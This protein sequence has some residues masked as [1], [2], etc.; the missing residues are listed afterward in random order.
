MNGIHANTVLC[1]NNEIV[2][3]SLDNEA[4]MMCIEK[5]SYYGLDAIGNDVWQYLAEPRSFESVCDYLL[6]RYSVDKA[7]C[8]H[9]VEKFLRM[10]IGQEL[11]EAS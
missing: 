8:E 11:I 9:D 5:G 4:V 1:R 2:S 10:M 7:V 3:T 6:N